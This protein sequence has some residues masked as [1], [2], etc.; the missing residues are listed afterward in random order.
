ML[1]SRLGNRV[2]LDI[3]QFISHYY[4]ITLCLIFFSCS[5]NF[6]HMYIFEFMHIF[7]IQNFACSFFLYITISLY[8][9]LQLLLNVFSNGPISLS[10]KFFA[11]PCFFIFLSTSRFLHTEKKITQ[12][13]HF[14]NCS[15]K[16][17]FCAFSLTNLSLNLTINAH[18]LTNLCH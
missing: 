1:W 10:T 11:S 3:F 5:L 13:L 8:I 17:I 4:I 9:V 14:I 15:L 16:L 12:F 18:N 7:V 6:S 2:Y